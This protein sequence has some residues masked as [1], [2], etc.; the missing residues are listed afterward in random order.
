MDYVV[1]THQV[2][3]AFGS[4]E[5]IRGVDL[6]IRQGETYGLLGPNGAGKT[7][8]IRM[9]VGLLRPTAGRVVVLGHEMPDKAVP[10]CGTRC[11]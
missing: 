2:K 7:T 11:G 9:L 5:A 4:F 10:A 1:Q 8:L 3:R 6:S